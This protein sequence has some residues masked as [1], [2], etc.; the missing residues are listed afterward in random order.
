M[1]NKNLS[2]KTIFLIIIF[3]IGIAQTWYTWNY[4]KDKLSDEALEQAR[5]IARSIDT[6]ELLNLSNNSSDLTKPEYY[7]IREKLKYI[8]EGHS[9]CRFLYLMGQK[10]DGTV[11]FILDSQPNGSKD[12][13]TPGLIYEEVSEEYKTVFRN[14]VEQTVGPIEDRWGRLVTSLI[15]IYEKGNSEN[16]I[17]VLG[18]DIEVGDWYSMLFSQIV[19]P[20]IATIFIVILIFLLFLL[21]INR[22][23]L[24]KVHLEKSEMVEKLQSTLEDVKQLKGILP[25]CAKCKKIRD[26]KGYWKQIESY[27]SKHTEA[28]FSH[29]ICPECTEILYPDFYA[30]KFKNSKN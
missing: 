26:D 13:V 25:I 12:G 24:K 16:M 5:I 27:I 22:I 30:K 20:I 23:H 14:R 7:S 21:N 19:F 17:A 1:A 18:M 10:N 28:D 9:N 11:Y 3:T 4:I 29:S 2:F 15:P 8:R 6:D